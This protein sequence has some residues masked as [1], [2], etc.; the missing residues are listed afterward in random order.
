MCTENDEHESIQQYYRVQ[1]WC[2][3]EIAAGSDFLFDPN[4]FRTTLKRA[5]Q[6]FDFHYLSLQ[7]FFRSLHVQHIKTMTFKIRSNN[8][9]ATKYLPEYIQQKKSIRRMAQD[10]NFS[11][12]LMAR[13]V[14]EHVAD[15]K[16]A[17]KK[18]L[19]NAMRDPIGELGALD[20]IQQEYWPSEF[21][22]GDQQQGD[23][24]SITRLATEVKE[25]VDCDPLSGPVSDRAKHFIGIEYELALEHML[26]QR[27]E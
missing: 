24:P 27:G 12:Y 23:E 4:L 20:S 19:I 25:A 18:S 9:F 7:S 6:D 10:A 15:W 5:S 22:L 13:L 1:H 21:P 14:V 3:Q 17:N 11:P 2:R 16:D 26:T 8:R